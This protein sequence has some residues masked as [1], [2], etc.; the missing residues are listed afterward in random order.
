MSVLYQVT[1]V[2]TIPGD[3]CQYYT[4]GHVSILYQV[5]C[6]NTIPGE[7]WPVFVSQESIVYQG[8]IGRYL[9]L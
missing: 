5:T 9:C 3:M 2:N 6:V 8:K 7:N 4:R 1:C